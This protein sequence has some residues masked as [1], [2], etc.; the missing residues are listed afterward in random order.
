MKQEEKTQR[1]KNKIYEAALREFG[2]NGYA[3]GSVNRICE[4]GI[5]KGLIYHNFKDKDELYLE[6]VKKSCEAFISYIVLHKGE[7]GFVE[8]MNTRM[9]FFA[10]HENE[11]A[12][13]LETRTH[14]PYH[15]REQ[16]QDIY[17]EFDDLNMAIL[18]REL[19]RHSLRQEVSREEALRY[20]LLI[21]KAYNFDFM[22]K[23]HPDMSVQEQIALHE[24]DLYKIFDLLLYGIAQRR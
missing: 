23:L 18:E 21:Q 3:A 8:Y 4:A 19:C 1:T 16:I 2:T 14:P 20:F 13:F 24:K 11:A 12:L 6:C 7:E 9:H 10:E 17:A 15:L 22:H 5:N